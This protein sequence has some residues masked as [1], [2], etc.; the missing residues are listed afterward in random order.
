MKRIFT[1]LYGAVG[2]AAFVA[3]F[4]YAI[5]FVRN[6]AVPKSMD[7]PAA[8]R[9]QTALLIDLGHRQQVP[10]IVP[11]MPRRIVIPAAVM[12]APVIPTRP[13]SGAR[14]IIAN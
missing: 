14:R 7:S 10:M 3:T 12:L 2:Y 4:L 9:W 8:G 13:G 6:F 11:G 5:G 1:F